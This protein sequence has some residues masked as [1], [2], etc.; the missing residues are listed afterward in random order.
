MKIAYFSPFSPLKSGISDFSEELVMQ[1]KDVDQI[2]IDIFTEKPKE[3][4]PKLAKSFE[5]FN[6]DDIHNDFLRCQYDYLLFQ[7]GNSSKYH[8]KIVDVFM[9]YGGILELHD[10]YL[11]NYW[12]ESTINLKN[13]NGLLKIMEECHG[14]EGKRVAKKIIENKYDIIPN[15][16][17]LK[18][19]LNKTLIDRAL[20]VIVHS[21]YA[22]QMVKTIKPDANVKKIMHHTADLIEDYTSYKK[23]CREELNIPEDKFIIASFGFA[24]VNKRILSI[25]EA[26]KRYNDNNDKKIYY[27]IVGEIQESIIINKIKKLK[28]NDYVVTV[29]YKELDEFK[30]YMGACD[31]VL[32]LR[33]PTQGESSGSLHRSLGMGK[34]IIATNIGAFMEY[35]D[36]VVLKVS[37]KEDEVDDIYRAISKLVSNKNL[38]KQYEE[39]AY[40]YAY[41]KCN[42]KTNAENY[43][44]LFFSLFCNYNDGYNYVEEADVITDRLFELGLAEDK[45]FLEQFYKKINLGI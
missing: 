14:S 10:V 20:A 3:I 8:K 33:Y 36:D 4:S 29:G 11:F 21:D 41:S 34:P 45:A 9:Q 24:S 28:L 40:N 23:K 2:F 12:L 44:Y 5:V 15:D 38:L 25:L 26:L 42:L 27:Y 7:V 1:L 32:N 19:P 39:N 43:M 18:F 31:I 30:K 37:Y 16:L 22:R 13:P 17:L 35:P 6:I